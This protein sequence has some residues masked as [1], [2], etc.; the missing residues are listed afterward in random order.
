MKKMQT[1][2]A[3]CP[4]KKVGTVQFDYAWMETDIKCNV[5]YFSSIQ[6]QS[7]AFVEFCLAIVFVQWIALKLQYFVI[8]M[9]IR[10]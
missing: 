4:Q 6:Q 3:K 5:L 1:Q 9:S 7:Y 8:F 10:K 2:R